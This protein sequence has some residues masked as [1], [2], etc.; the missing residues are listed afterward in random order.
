MTEQKDDITFSEE[1]Y[2]ESEMT[3]IAKNQPTSS[4][5]AKVS[6]EKAGNIFRDLDKLN[7]D[8]E[9]KGEPKV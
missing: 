1:E 7:N 4:R 6:K 9:F 3:E 5:P 8:Y 2:A